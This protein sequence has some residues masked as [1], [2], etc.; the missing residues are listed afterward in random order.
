[1]SDCIYDLHPSHQPVTTH[2]YSL[3]A[4]LSK[5]CIVARV[6]LTEVSLQHHGCVVGTAMMSLLLFVLAAEASIL[7]T[8]AFHQTFAPTLDR[9]SRPRASAMTAKKDGGLRFCQQ[10]KTGQPRPLSSTKTPSHD[11][12]P[13]TSDAEDSSWALQQALRQSQERTLD[14]F[15]E[16][17]APLWLRELQQHDQQNQL[18]P[19]EMSETNN[20]VPSS[21]TTTTTP[22]A[23]P[24]SCTGCGKC[25]R[26]QGDVYM[27]PED[28]IAAACLLDITPRMF[29]H[30]YAASYILSRPSMLEG[31][32][33][34]DDFDRILEDKQVWV[35]LREAK[36]SGDSSTGEACIF[37]DETTNQC[38]IYEARPAQCRTYPFWPSILLSPEKWN[39]E[40]RRPD[41]SSARDNLPLWTAEDG[42]CEGMKQVVMDDQTGRVGYQDDGQT[43]DDEEAVSVRE[44]CRQ[45]F[46]YSAAE[47]R[48]P[49]DAIKTN[50]G[51]R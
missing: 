8:D 42:G 49:K 37:L 10:R 4:D 47:R 24:F 6:S 23:L 43:G 45:L 3:Y 33:N 41:D 28:I 30:Q 5:L 44:A 38:Q 1:M 11:S 17:E 40:C 50:L 19:S 22:S 7:T 35:R 2:A 14:R 16:T 29:V 18:G 25:C 20:S 31:I 13:V 51:T 26:T 12:L 32:Q 15:I 48:F 27:A 9:W 46:E 36:R 39:E 34:S 21:T